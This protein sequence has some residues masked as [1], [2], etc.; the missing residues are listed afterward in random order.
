MQLV[1]RMSHDSQLWNDLLWTSGGALE[2][3]KCSF[4][5][6]ESRWDKLSRP[7]LRG[8]LADSCLRVRNG[9]H[10]VQIPQTGNYAS[11]KTLGVH[12]NPAG[13]MKTQIKML[14]RNSKK[15][16]DFVLANVLTCREAQMLY[17]AIYLPSMTYPMAVTHMKAVECHQ[18]ETRFF[19]ALLPR[20]GFPRSMFTAIRH[21]PAS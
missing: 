14:Q 19:Q 1:E 17:N 13:L 18:V 2:L 5:V 9:D 11:R 21:A 7:F 15:F 8:G 16:E 12:L 20:M 6:I 3:P 10:E 4:Q